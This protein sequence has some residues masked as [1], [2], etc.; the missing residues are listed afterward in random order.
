MAR[1]L[2][3]G[4]T[5]WT[6]L[7]GFRFPPQS[8]ARCK[9]VADACL[10]N[11]VSWTLLGTGST[12][13]YRSTQPAVCSDALTCENPG[14]N[15]KFR[16]R[17]LYLNERPYAAKLDP[18]YINI[19]PYAGPRFTVPIYQRLDVLHNWKGD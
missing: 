17:R 18:V 16:E 5:L 12:L 15:E 8:P 14:S 9:T 1:A 2:L 6:Q 7:T 19:S 13:V 4:A 3:L 11:S 10:S